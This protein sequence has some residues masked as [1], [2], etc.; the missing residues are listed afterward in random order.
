VYKTAGRHGIADSRKIWHSR[1]G[2]SS[3]IKLETPPNIIWR[4]QIPLD[5]SKLYGESRDNST[6]LLLDTERYLGT[7]LMKDISVET[8]SFYSDL[9]IQQN[10]ALCLR[11]DDWSRGSESTPTLIE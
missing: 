10:L 11:L 6:F 1:F 4:T 9:L 8:K 2:Q 7:W 5:P 3:R